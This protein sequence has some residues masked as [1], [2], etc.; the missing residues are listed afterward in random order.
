MN[1]AFHMVDLAHGQNSKIFFDLGPNEAL[2]AR[3]AENA[4]VLNMVSHVG[5]FSIA[6]LASGAKAA[7][8]VD[9]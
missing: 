1:K 8:S 5:D 2:V 4:Y 9:G 7:I 6:A 3:L